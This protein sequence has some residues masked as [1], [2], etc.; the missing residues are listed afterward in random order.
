MNHTKQLEGRKCPVKSTGIQLLLGILVKKKKKNNRV[1]VFCL[2]CIGLKGCQVTSLLAT[3]SCTRTVLSPVL[4]P[5]FAEPM[6]RVNFYTESINNLKTSGEE[7]DI[8]NNL[9]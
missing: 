4:N 1:L 8:Q 3:C 6:S 9:K 5:C 2:N 7:G